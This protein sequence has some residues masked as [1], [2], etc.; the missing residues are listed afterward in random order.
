M[1]SRSTASGA[2]HESSPVTDTVRAETLLQPEGLVETLAQLRP[3]GL[4]P[5]AIMARKPQLTPPCPS[6]ATPH[7][8]D[9]L[10]LN[11]ASRFLRARADL[12]H[13]AV[14]VQ[15]MSVDATGNRRQRCC[16]QIS[17][18]QPFGFS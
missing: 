10:N 2:N 3:E 12:R 16:G 1:A 17:S 15:S 18:Q 6:P 5:S 9:T 14:S 8:A 13:A 4:S 11:S 7:A